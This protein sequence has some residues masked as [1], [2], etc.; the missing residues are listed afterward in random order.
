MT[1]RALVLASTPALFTGALWMGCSS[2]GDA[3]AAAPDAGGEA[4][5]L[6]ASV[7]PAPASSDP[8]VQ[9][10][11]RAVLARG[12]PTCHQSTDPRDGVLSGSVAPVPGTQ[13]YPRNLTPDPDTGL[14]A[15]D[16][17]T[18]ARAVRAG[19]DD[20]DEALCPTMPKFSDMKDDEANAI[21]AYLQSL[22]AVHHDIPDSVCADKPA[23]DAGQGGD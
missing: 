9:A 4:A 8:N 1:A 5:P 14:D 6:D 10:G 20:Q 2:S 21:A 13:T 16:A 3:P 17:A 19:I 15:W 18:I 23:N 22:P 7:I 11:Y 12:C